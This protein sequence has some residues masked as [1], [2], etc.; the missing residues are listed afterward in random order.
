[1]VALWT[2]ERLLR[3]I[4][5]R[6]PTEPLLDPRG[7]RME[8]VYPR[9]AFL[10]LGRIFAVSPCRRPEHNFVSSKIFHAT[11]TALENLVM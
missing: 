11:W 2:A 7:L 1:M 5:E 6:I 9:A 8:M 4:A 10:A 3:G